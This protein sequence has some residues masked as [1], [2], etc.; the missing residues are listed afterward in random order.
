MYTSGSTGTPKGVL[1]TH[2][3]VSRLVLN[4]GYAEF[5]SSDR[6]ALAANPAFDASTLEVWAPLLNGGSVV[7]IEREVLLEPA[8]LA[9][10]LLAQS[11]SVLWLTV[12]LFNQY[13]GALSAVIPRLRYL[14]VGGDALDPKVISRVLREHPP[15]HLLNGYGPTETTTFALTHEVRVVADEATSIP[16][17]RPIG[18]TTVY[19]LDGARRPVPVGVAGELYIGG[20]GVAL[21][22]LNR[23]EL[24]AERFVADPFAAGERGAR[25]YKTGD[26]G[27]WLPD[28]TVEFLGRNDFQVKVRGFRVE[29]GEIESRLSSLEGVS[30]VVVLAREDEPGD[31]RLVAYYAGA[32][33][34]DAEAVR[35]HARE[36]LP[37][38]MVP[39]AYVRLESLPLT[40]NGKIDRK[41]LPAPEG[42]AY[43]SHGYEAPQGEVETQLASLWADVLKVERVGRHDNFFELGGH[44]LLAVTLTERM[45]RA[46]LHAD[47]RAL[48]TTATLAELAAKVGG[49]SGEVVVPANRIPADATRIT[50]EMLP[51]VSLSQEAIDGIVSR[52]P[53]GAANVQDIYPLA[54]LQEGIL[55]HHLMGGEGDAYLLPT[56]LAFKSRERL[57]AFVA[58][59]QAVIDRHDILRTAVMWEGLREP[60]QV[61]LRRA[62]LPVETVACEPA[63]GRRGRAAEGAYDPRR[64]RIDVREAPLLRGFAAE[65]A[66]ERAVAAADAGTPPGDRSHDAAAAD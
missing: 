47:V 51:L 48:F 19:I 9:S 8:R 24:T 17:G 44:S 16:L 30:E 57:D 12:G 50:P 10:E 6:V 52:V 29:L 14:L 55:F 37:E 65:D 35:E 40:A 53:G 64:Y 13:V 42:D 66:S 54:P 11:V 63:T 33:A 45:R 15:E 1:V 38:Y 31:K 4:N 59:L 26:L 25:M 27:R 23:P 56:L 61:V 28:G 46:G 60:V 3:G 2:R 62:T 41:A 43:V 58:T 5:R 21:G 7:V 18:N 36:G 20:D 39:A 49:E 34:P 22:Y 32:N